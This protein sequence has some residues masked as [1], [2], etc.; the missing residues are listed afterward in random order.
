MIAVLISVLIGI[1]IGYFL[2]AKFSLN[3]LGNLS[4]IRF[5]I[6]V[7]PNPKFLSDVA[8]FQAVILAFLLPLSI[9][10]ISRLSERYKSEVVSSLF[11]NRWENILFPYVLIFNIILAIVMRFFVDDNFNNGLTLFLAWLV[12]LVFL[13]NAYLTFRVVAITKSMISDTKILLG[14]LFKKVEDYLE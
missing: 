6:S 13:F 10:I 8:A 1:Y 11:K 5:F 14:L 4:V 3:H 9:E 12:L 7:T 2:S